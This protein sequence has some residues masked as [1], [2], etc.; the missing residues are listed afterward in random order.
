ML[1]A[2]EDIEPESL[3]GHD[4]FD[5]ASKT[6]EVE[7]WF[8]SELAEEGP[9]ELNHDHDHGFHR[10]DPNRHG[11]DIR[12]FSLVFREPINWTAFG[13]WL[14]MLLNRHGEA[15]LRVKGLLSIDGESAPVAV[16]AVQQLVHSPTH[17]GRWPSTDRRTRIVF[18]CKGL[19]EADV[20]RSFDSFVRKRKLALAGC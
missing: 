6:R 10:H 19:E 12:A 15:I 11:E 1:G 18:I 3:I 2:E 4:L 17:L 5:L 20:R 9:H 14:S 16:H 13:L 8:E 7:H